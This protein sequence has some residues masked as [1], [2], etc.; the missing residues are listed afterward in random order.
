MKLI[1]QIPCYNEEKTLG[2]TLS[3]LPRK[4]ENIESVEWMIIDDGSTDKTLEVAKSYGVD[5]IVAMP[6]HVGLA[7]SFLHGIKACVSLGADMIVN[8]DADNQYCAEDISKLI[9]PVLNGYADMS[10]G[11]RPIEEIAHFS[12]AKKKLQRIGSAVIRWISRTPVEDAACGFRRINRKA[13][14]RI[15]IFSQYSYT[16]ETIIQASQADLKISS[17][18]IRVNPPLRPSRLFQSMFAYLW[19]SAWTV[20]RSCFNYYPFST[21]ILF[22]LFFLMAGLLFFT[23]YIMAASSIFFLV[24]GFVFLLVGSMCFPLAFTAEQI[25]INRMML[26]EILENSSLQKKEK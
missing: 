25:Q 2:C 6:C 5:H 18:P 8:T 10:I 12:F 16:L 26:E 21:F 13:A 15:R 23:L 1:I 4:I 11:S 22:C 19:Y 17:V 9:S 7:K 14:I 20:V 24:P 3:C